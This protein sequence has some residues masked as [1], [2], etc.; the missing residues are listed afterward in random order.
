MR[1]GP[2]EEELELARLAL[3]LWI[4]VVGERVWIW[5]NMSGWALGTVKEVRGSSTVLVSRL[6]S[7]GQGVR[8]KRRIR[9]GHVLPM[10]R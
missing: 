4:P 7:R 5:V 6:G 9:R 3:R 1:R 2:N 10:I 8:E